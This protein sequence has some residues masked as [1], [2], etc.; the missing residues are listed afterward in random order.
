MENGWLKSTF[1]SEETFGAI[2]DDGVIAAALAQ[3]T[4][5]EREPSAAPR[6]PRQP[7]R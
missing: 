2:T 7:R 6:P 3:N 4:Q 1:F 5:S